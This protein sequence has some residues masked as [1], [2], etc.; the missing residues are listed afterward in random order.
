MSLALGALH[1]AGSS[2]AADG[3]HTPLNKNVLLLKQRKNIL[4]FKG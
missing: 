1:R 4:R 3:T 2:W